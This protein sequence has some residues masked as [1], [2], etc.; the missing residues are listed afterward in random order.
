MLRAKRNTGSDPSGLNEQ[1]PKGVHGKAL[2]TIL[3]FSALINSSLNIEDVLNYAMQCAEEFMDAEASTVYELHEAKNELFV[4]VARGEKRAP[5]KRI[6]M[7]RIPRIAQRLLSNVPKPVTTS[8]AGSPMAAQGSR[9]AG[10][11]P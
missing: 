3:R 2:D 4:R 1:G 8:R 9:S 10:R 11:I 6:I 5:V 7:A